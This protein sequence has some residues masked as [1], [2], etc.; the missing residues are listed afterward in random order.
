MLLSKCAVWYS[1]KTKFIKQQQTS[2]LLSS[3]EIK[4]PLIKIPVLGMSYY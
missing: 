3:L 1:K 2:G 4:T